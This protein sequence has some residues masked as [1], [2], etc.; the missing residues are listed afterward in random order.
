[1]PIELYWNET[2]TMLLAEYLPNGP[3]KRLDQW[4]NE[5]IQFF[6][7]RISQLRPRAYKRLC[8][9]YGYGP[10]FAY[11][12]VYQFAACNFSSRDG[13]ADIDS[14]YNIIVERVPCPIRHKCTLGYCTNYNALS[15]REIDIVKLF[16]RGS[17][18]HSIAISLFIAPSTVHNHMTNIYHKLGFTGH[19][20]PERLLLSYAYTNKII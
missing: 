11:Y 18:E 14:D 5:D 7:E 13:H 12:R 10:Q 15:E 8:D 9:E 6:D 17:D 2:R 20:H 4:D 16:A 1:M 3:V 19:A